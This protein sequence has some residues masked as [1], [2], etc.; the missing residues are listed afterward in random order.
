MTARTGSSV[1]LHVAMTALSASTTLPIAKAARLLGVH[2]NTLRAWSD[3]GR[4]PCLR[5]NHRGD[6]RFRLEDLHAFM[7]EAGGEYRPGP[8]PALM[9]TPS[10][11]SENATER[12][13]DWEARI[14][15]I[16]ELGTRLNCLGSVGEI[17]AAICV[18]LRQLIDYH[19]V[20]VYRV[21]GADVVPVAW[22]GE[23]GTY[24][25]EDGGQLRLRVG[26]GITGW[27]AQHG[28]AQY[29]P[30][31]AADPR[32]EHMPG[33]EEELAESLLV[34]PMLYEDHAIGVI[35]LAKLGLDRFSADELRY[36]VIYASVAAQA[37]ANALISER[38]RAQEQMLDRQL[39]SQAELLRVTERILTTLDPATVIAEIADSLAGLIP[40]DTLGIYVHQPAE[41][42]L[43]P[44]LARGVGAKA[45]MARRLP[46]SGE[47][48]SEV[49]ATGEARS[50]R[51]AGR[52]KPA[53]AP[54]ALI[55]A[56]LRGP[57]RVIGLLHLKRL[58]PD[59]RFESREFDLV[60]LFAA[61]VSIALQ[62]ALAHK[63]VEL[64]AQTDALTG[65]RNH[66]TFRDDVRSAIRRQLPFALLM[67]DLDEFKAYNDRYGHEAGN[68]LLKR[69]ARTI[70]GACRETD[71]VYRY[72]GDEFCVVLPGASLPDAVEVAE[73]VRD[74][75]AQVG[76][77]G[78]AREGV[79][80]SIG[81]AT[82]PEDG[83][84][85]ADLLLAADRALY[86]AKRAGRDRVSTADDGL[87]LA[88]EFVS[89]HTPVDEL[90]AGIG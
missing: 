47:V 54:A 4:I 64:R 78:W 76:G 60:R 31:A 10:T 52:A 61:H 84:A 73:R 59:A 29:L 32:G 41:R 68:V 11:S 75:I 39:H 50:V 9:V 62:N 3:E 35:V 36:L 77:D 8:S 43:E 23:T 90:E 74:A 2:P 86:A 38:L 55:L 53:S 65:L 79:H 27:V 69:L 34:A 45:F 66:G 22:R 80:C 87:A 40:V 21:E 81:I 44:L 1:H 30:D 58:G 20:R 28:V 7:F 83:P 71:L 25:G 24:T 85:R 49:L 88:A 6:R 42:S 26:E 57:D 48:V 19:N 51:R 14:D 12:V 15:S 67:L 82:W 33:T 18:E 37:M 72:G 13:A 17:G 46:D 63:A 89:P 16:A 70:G 56:P 5:V